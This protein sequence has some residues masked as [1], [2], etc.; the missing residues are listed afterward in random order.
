MNVWRGD[1]E[2]ISDVHP[3]FMNAWKSARAKVGHGLAEWRV[4]HSLLSL[5]AWRRERQLL[6]AVNS[7]FH[8]KPGE[9]GDKKA[10]RAL[11]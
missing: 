2:H 9:N 3:C 4:C 11:G 10:G 6:P 5:M 7:P 1:V 8:P